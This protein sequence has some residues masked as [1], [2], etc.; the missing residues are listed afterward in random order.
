MLHFILSITLYRAAFE[1]LVIAGYDVLKLI[2]LLVT[3]V[4]MAY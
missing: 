4:E 1:L 2:W 3:M